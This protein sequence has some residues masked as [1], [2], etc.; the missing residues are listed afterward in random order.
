MS[1]SDQHIRWLTASRGLSSLALV[2]AVVASVILLFPSPLGDVFFSGIVLSSV[3]F[4]AIGVM[5]AW[6][7]R[8]PLV[9][10]AAFLL[11]G[12]TVVGLLSIGFLIAPGA[13]LMIGAAISGH[14]AGSRPSVR[15]TIIA[16]PPT[17]QN[18]V[19]RT[20]AGGFFTVAGIWLVYAGAFRQELFGA[21]ANESL[22]CALE[23]AHWDAIGLTV[24]GLSAVAIGGW[25]LWQQ[26]IIIKTLSA[27]RS[28]H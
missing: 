17:I 24:I 8:T 26:M 6:T 22:S 14:L 20:I 3:L 2:A 13:L 16:D 21:C 10:L 15:D 12:L 4:A 18:R 19:S 11:V 7:N 1:A 28:D 5:G 25:L 9:W 23:M 27:T